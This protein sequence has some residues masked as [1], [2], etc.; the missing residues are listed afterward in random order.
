[1]V[2]S[3]ATVSDR[4][5]SCS[6]VSSS[7]TDGGAAGLAAPRAER[8]RIATRRSSIIAKK[9]QPAQRSQQH[10]SSHRSA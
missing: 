5:A 2:P 3:C 1:M 7:Q 10:P 6:G 9:P 8:T 4:S